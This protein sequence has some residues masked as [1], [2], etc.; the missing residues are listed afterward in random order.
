MA[1]KSPL[2]AFLLSIV[3][4]LGQ[5]YAGAYSRAAALLLGL[6]LQALLFW[7][8]SRPALN[9]WLVLFWIWN[10]F[11]AVRLARGLDADVVLTARKSRRAEGARAAA[12]EPELHGTEGRL[13]TAACRRGCRE[14]VRRCRNLQRR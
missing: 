3:P 7:L 1:K 6:P 9:V 5:L 13:A 10:L 4:G 2:A 14:K 11:D 8:V 12:A